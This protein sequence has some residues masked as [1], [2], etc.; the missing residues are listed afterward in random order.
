MEAAST[1]LFLTSS[2]SQTGSAYGVQ[3]LE[4]TIEEAGNLGGE[5][6]ERREQR[7]NRE[8][9]RDGGVGNSSQTSST[10]DHV[11][12]VHA[13]EPPTSS[14]GTESGSPVHRPRGNH[15]A[16][17]FLM[18]LLFPSR[19]PEPSLPS[20]P[21]SVS[22]KSLRSLKPED[23]D[24]MGDDAASQAIISSE[25]EEED[26]DV[27]AEVQDSAPQLIMPSIK[28]P[29][30]RPFTSRGKDMGRLKVLIVGESGSAPSLVSGFP[31]LHKADQHR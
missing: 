23:F 24:S 22:S 5:D 10:G 13:A 25:E 1:G 16:A 4:D 26:V 11:S 21:I 19:V 12:D 7:E 3:S 27:S 14:V 20:S 2:T 29:S 18:P 15:P 6:E 9:I 30:R 31:A 17:R 8:R 28:M